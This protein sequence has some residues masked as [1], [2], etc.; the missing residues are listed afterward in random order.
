MTYHTSTE[1]RPIDIINIPDLEAIVQAK[2][3]KGAFGYLAGGAES[4]TTLR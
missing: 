2:M 4:E 1:E 3:N